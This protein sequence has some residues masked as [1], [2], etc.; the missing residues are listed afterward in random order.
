MK[1]IIGEIERVLKQG[2]ELYTSMGSKESWMF[3][4]SGFPKIDENTILNKEDG[5]ENNVPHFYA[6]REDILTI[7]NNFDIEEIRHIDY[8]Y[9]NHKKV[10]SKHYYVNAR[11]K[12]TV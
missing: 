11:K 5:P 8:C 3:T 7:F 1:K 10:D 6:N 4:K 9:I 2:G 12:G